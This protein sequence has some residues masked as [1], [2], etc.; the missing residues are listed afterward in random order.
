MIP[1]E[2]C[3][4]SLLR[5]FG[6]ETVLGALAE[7]FT[8]EEYAPGDVIVERGGQAD[9]VC[10]I[11]HGKV[12][13][14]GTGEYGDETVLATMVD[15]DHFGSAALVED[16]AAW[17]ATAKAVTPCTVLSLRRSEFHEVADRSEALRAHLA[18]VSSRPSRE[19][20]S[21]GEATIAVAAGH[22][23]EPDLPGTFVDYEAAP[24]EYELS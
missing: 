13:R 1:R 4:L 21:S 11:A 16:E 2:L 17:D 10:L 15:G 6:D 20:D 9:R 18:Q 8:Q 24:R 19:V 3:E 23:G 12:N 22:T 14:L 5:D 7:R